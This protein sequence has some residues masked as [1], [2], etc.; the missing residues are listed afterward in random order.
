VAAPWL[1]ELQ[2]FWRNNCLDIGNLYRRS[3]WRLILRR[4]REVSRRNTPH[5]LDIRGL[6]DA[7]ARAFFESAGAHVPALELGDGR[8]YCDSHIAWRSTDS[9]VVSLLGSG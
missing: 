9:R 6:E 8:F 5:A 7:G 2:L 3:R 1:L 4:R